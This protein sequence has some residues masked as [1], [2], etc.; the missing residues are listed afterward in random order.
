MSEIAAA[1]HEEGAPVPRLSGMEFA[2]ALG[3]SAVSPANQARQRTLQRMHEF[4]YPAMTPEAREIK[5]INI[6]YYVLEL[7]TG[8]KPYE[9]VMD[10]LNSP[11]EPSSEVRQAMVND[12]LLATA[13][14]EELARGIAELNSQASRLAAWKSMKELTGGYSKDNTGSLNALHRMT[15]HNVRLGW[16]SSASV[17]DCEY[18]LR[19]LILLEKGPSPSGLVK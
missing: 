1:P 10:A 15:L 12:F 14:L 4:D 7:S 5:K 9:E 6:T 8:L 17:G 18:M 16:I 11:D 19:R 2:V 3:W 13:V